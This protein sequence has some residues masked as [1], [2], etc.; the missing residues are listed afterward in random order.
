MIHISGY[1]L[2]LFALVNSMLLAILNSFLFIVPLSTVKLIY[3]FSSP[4]PSLPIAL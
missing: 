4:Y 2:F 3:Y 1:L